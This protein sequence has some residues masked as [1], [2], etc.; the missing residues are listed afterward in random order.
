MKNFFKA[1]KFAEKA[2]SFIATLNIIGKTFTPLE[3][4]SKFE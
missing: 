3:A 1:Y 2:F 4:D